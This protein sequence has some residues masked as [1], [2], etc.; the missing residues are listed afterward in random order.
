MRSS[1][2]FGPKKA[3]DIVLQKAYERARS[4]R[5]QEAIEMSDFISD[6]GEENVANDK[7]QVEEI[8]ERFKEES[9]EVRDALRL[10]TILE[11]IITEQVELSEWLGPEVHTRKASR[12]DD[13]INK[14]DVIA[15]VEH[16]HTPTHLALAIDVTHGRYLND[17]FNDIK[18]EIETGTLTSVKYFENADQTF[19]GKLS[20][21][22]RVVLGMDKEALFELT[23]LW[24][25]GNNTKLAA[26][27]VQLEILEE[28]QL[29][30]EQYRDYALRCDK[31]DL[32]KIYDR[33][34]RIIES[35]VSL[36]EKQE[37]A[38][39]YD[40]DRGYRTHDETYKAI[41]LGARKFSGYKPSLAA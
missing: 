1:F 35:I 29:Q 21:V 9:Q 18:R 13:L 26:H 14:V 7:L 30:L 41:R 28:I 11:A 15:E 32:V 37:L 5:G 4:G 36:P 3:S 16:E 8:E 27:P 22:P 12:Y 17:K 39:S 6:Y 2:E 33:Q 19:K 31:D 40:A 24:M 20:K 38:R 25:E 10:A 34:L 23:E